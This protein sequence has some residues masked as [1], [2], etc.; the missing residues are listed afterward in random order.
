M[1]LL[2]QYEHF[3]K[4]H[5]EHILSNPVSLLENTVLFENYIEALAEAIEDPEARQ[6]F[7]KVAQREREFLLTEATNLLGTEA[8]K[9]WAVMYYPLLADVYATPVISKILTTFTTNNPQV[10]IP[11]K[12]VKGEI[13]QLDGS[14]KTVDLPST[15][16]VRPSEVVKTVGLG[17]NNLI[18]L[19]GI[20]DVKATINTR[21]FAI[22]KITITEKYTDSTGT[23][24]TR[25]IDIDVII[26]PDFS[27]NIN[28]EYEA[29]DIDGKTIKGY[30]SGKVDFKSGDI[31]LSNTF[32]YDGS[33][34]IE[35][36]SATV[37][38][39]VNVYGSDIGR[40]RVYVDATDEYKIKVDED[41]SFL[42]E[43]V[44]EEVQ[45]LKD[46]YNLDILASAMEV[47]KLQFVLNKDADVSELLQLSEP[48]MQAH[49]N[50]ATVDFNALP[51]AFNPS[52]LADLYA[53]IVPRILKVRNAIRKNAHVEPQYLLCSPNT[54]TLIESLQQYGVMA[55]QANNMKLGPTGSNITFAKFNVVVSE[56]LPDNKIYVVF[57]APNK[58]QAALLDIVY[59][60]LYIEKAVDGGVTKQYL[61][62]RTTVEVVDTKKLG[63]VEL[64]NVDKVL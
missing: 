19:A 9:A 44:T 42:I 1:L 25:D 48:E 15:S 55:N 50:V 41:N 33:S 16:A 36:K 27:G 5:K 32:E 30:I 63:V 59:K 37:K 20:K 49:G 4:E 17:K 11:R 45:D 10:A 64:Q 34:E 60:P 38:Y 21:Y 57:K 53:V 7:K 56:T 24:T 47:V 52:N 3:V 29:K 54:A 39:R 23:T 18:S 26:R 51:S 8:G 13:I 61:K 22:T 14:T 46:I 58:Q 2:E 12:I 62:S 43:L 35:F 28:G 31:I 40:V 6:A